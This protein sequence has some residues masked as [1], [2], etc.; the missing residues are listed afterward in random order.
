MN[1][2]RCGSP[3]RFSGTEQ[4]QLGKTGFLTGT[5]S[6]LFS[7]T[8]E[9]AIYRCTHCGKIEFFSTEDADLSDET[10]QRTCPACGFEHDF[11]DPKCPKCGHHYDPDMQIPEQRRG[12]PY[13]R[14]STGCDR[15]TK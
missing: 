7:G 14:Q 1:C 8:L 15:H 4:I 10:T 6:N 3:M 5:L 9:V 11:D 13:G 2:L 12:E